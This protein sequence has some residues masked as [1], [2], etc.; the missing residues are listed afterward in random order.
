MNDMIHESIADM[1]HTIVKVCVKIDMGLNGEK[2]KSGDIS[3]PS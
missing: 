2:Y 3:Q 1:T